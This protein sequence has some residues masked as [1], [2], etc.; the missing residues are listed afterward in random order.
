MEVDEEDAA[1]VAPAVQSRVEVAA[2]LAAVQSSS[3]E[4]AALLAVQCSEDL[5]EKIGRC[6]CDPFRPAAACAYATCCR[7][8]LAVMRP[9]LDELRPQRAQRP[10]CALRP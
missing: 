6:M 9:L 10:Q 3:E 2:V 4:V 5:L 8:L 7:G 1:A